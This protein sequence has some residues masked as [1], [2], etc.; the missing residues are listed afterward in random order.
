MQRYSIEENPFVSGDWFINDL[1]DDTAFGAF[2]TWGEAY[3]HMIKIQTRVD[4]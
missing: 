4:V 1:L 3:R 2:K